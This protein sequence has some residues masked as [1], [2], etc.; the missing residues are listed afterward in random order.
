MRER[1]D[2]IGAKIQYL[3][4]PKGLGTTLEIMIPRDKIEKVEKMLLHVPASIT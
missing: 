3:N 4:K 1:A 2:L